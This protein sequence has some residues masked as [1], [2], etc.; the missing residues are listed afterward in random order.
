MRLLTNDMKVFATEIYALSRSGEIKTF[1]GKP[2][3][4]DS[5]AEAEAFCIRFMP[6]AHVVPNDNPLAD[7]V[8]KALD[9]E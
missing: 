3:V 2:V 1:E 4:A 6:Y 7:L 9:T 8:T 5:Y